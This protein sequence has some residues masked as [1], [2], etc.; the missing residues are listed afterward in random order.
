MWV[1]NRKQ[2]DLSD[3]PEE[4]EVP[5]AHVEITATN[6]FALVYLKNALARFAPKALRLML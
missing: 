1:P 6:G 4:P 5:Y 3:T 2:A